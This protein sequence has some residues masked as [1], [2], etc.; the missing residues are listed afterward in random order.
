MGFIKWAV[1][2]EVNLLGYTIGQ[3]IMLF[4]YLTC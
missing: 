4:L 1:S 2:F 3:G